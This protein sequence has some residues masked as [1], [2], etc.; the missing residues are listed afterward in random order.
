M[1][2][3]EMNRSKKSKENLGGIGQEVDDLFASN[4]ENE[5]D[6]QETIKKVEE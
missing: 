3:L 4:I 5:E 1:S 6:N 2:E